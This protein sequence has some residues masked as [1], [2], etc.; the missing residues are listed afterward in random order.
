MK[1]G[2]DKIKGFFSGL[3]LSFPSIKL[4]HFSISGSFSLDPP[5]VPHISVKWYKRAMEGAYLLD[6][7]TLFA[8]ANG[9]AGGGEA[10]NEYI[11]GQNSLAN[12]VRAQ[13]DSALSA[14]LSTIINQLNEII[15]QGAT[16]Q[17]IYIDKDVLVGETV[18]AIDQKLGENRQRF[19]R[20][21]A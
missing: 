2:L 9:L 5:S 13:V 21:L 18:K 11:V 12:T 1:S 6:N 3:K 17:S 15:Q 8:T 10:G 20:G 14:G 7:P 16:G 19:R 4:P